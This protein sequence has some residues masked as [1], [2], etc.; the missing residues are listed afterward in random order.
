MAIVY[1]HRKNN[2][3]SIFYVGIGKSVSR[4]KSTKLRSDFWRNTANKYGYSYEVLVDDVSWEDA[5]DLECLIISMLGRRNKKTGILCNMTDGGDGVVGN[6]AWNKGLKISDYATYKK[7]KNVRKVKMTFKL[8]VSES[9][10]VK[11]SKS[12][13]GKIKPPHTK[14][15][16]L[17]LSLYFS[18]KVINTQT[19]EIFIGVKKLAKMLNIDYTSFA[20]KLKGTRKNNTIYK[21][22]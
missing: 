3:N 8:P 4:A 9:T 15:T 17:K 21:Y 19:G 1:I 20:K 18:K 7:I 6:T 2:D 10:K 14:E 12:L 5:C 11:L 13:K 16:K 22:I